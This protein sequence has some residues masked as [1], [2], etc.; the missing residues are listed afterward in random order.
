MPYTPSQDLV[1]ISRAQNCTLGLLTYRSL[2]RTQWYSI[3]SI[4]GANSGPP[5]PTQFRRLYM[6]LVRDGGVT[7]TEWFN[8]LHQ[9]FAAPVTASVKRWSLRRRYDI[10]CEA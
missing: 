6:P 5:I 2:G 3:I 1:S 10:S 4:N 8:M 9:N 7:R